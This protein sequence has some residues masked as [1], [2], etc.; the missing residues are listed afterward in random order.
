MVSEGVGVI[1]HEMPLETLVW[2]TTKPYPN[3][4]G[5]DL[6][7]SLGFRVLGFRV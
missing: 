4:S 5:P 3:S 6:T 2:L 7:L 1:S